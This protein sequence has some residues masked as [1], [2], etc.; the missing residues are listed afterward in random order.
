MKPPTLGVFYFCNL[1]TV[2][3]NQSVFSLIAAKTKTVC[4]R[5]SMHLDEKLYV[6]ATRH[7]N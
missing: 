1:T 7:Q 5:D 6:E 2:Y 3:P 4:Y